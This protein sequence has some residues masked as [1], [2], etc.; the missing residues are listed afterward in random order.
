VTGK[1]TVASESAGQIKWPE[2]EEEAVDWLR[3]YVRFP[4][5]NDPS[6]TSA[7][8]ERE[9][10]EWLAGLLRAEKVDCEL[11]ESAPGRANLVA[12][13]GPAEP[14][15][16]ITLLSHSDV[17]PAV[18]ADWA[19]DPFA[20]DIRDGQLYGRGV[21]DL[22][23]LGVAQ[24]ITV[25]LLR[26]LGIPLRRQVR[27]IIAA[28][29]E[30]GGSAGAQ[31]LLRHRPE[32]LDTSL[33]LGEGAYSPADVLPDGVP[34]HAIAV[35]EKGYLEL[36]LT[37]RGTAQHASTADPDAAP[38]RLVRALTRILD[39]RPA[40]RMTPPTK[41][42]CA[43]LARGATGLHRYILRHPRLI[44]RVGPAALHLN[45]L[46][47]SMLTDTCALTV[48]ASGYKTNV[49]PGE[50]RAV[51]SLRLLPGTDPAEVEQRIRRAAD[52]P[53]I[54]VR[55]T[56]HKAPTDSP[57]NTRD[58]GILAGQIT[59]PGLPVPILSP[60][61]S[62]AR[63]WRAAGVSA[64]GWVPFTLPVAD[65]HGVHGTNERISLSSFRA[66]LRQYYRAV[67]ELASTPYRR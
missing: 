57:F 35:A 44:E 45:P 21:L 26:R 63:H 32:F 48:L 23:G 7:G 25:I 14:A 43:S 37:A 66:G 22:K 54:E 36:E 42:L 3:T 58:Y 28:D 6:G 61:A 50:A 1:A 17:V 29:E 30:A 47:S 34:L 8:D 20:A 11:L 62:D 33:V 10:A 59:E 31:W 2:V 5:V 40:I 46:V 65:I 4:T 19:A 52:D 15:P 49:L 51:L 64:Y 9:A 67:A 60:G 39:Q 13:I 38:A 27:L 12:R 24:L 41:A 18:S 16:S 56:A 55:R 53:E